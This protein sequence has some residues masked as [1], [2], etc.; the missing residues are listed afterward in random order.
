LQQTVDDLHA[1]L[2]KVGEPG[3]YVLVGHSIGGLYTRKFIADHPD[4]VVGLVLVDAAHPEQLER[5]P[6]FET[7]RETYLR[8]SARFP[9]LARI[10][11]FRLYFAAGGEIDFAGLP[12]RQHDEVTAFWS[13]PEYFTSQR[14]ETI[15][16]P[17]IYADGQSL[18]DLGDLPLAVV[19]QG[20]ADQNWTALQEELA[21]LSSNSTHITVVGSTHGSL[22][23]D[24]QHAQETS[25]AILRIVEAARNNP[26]P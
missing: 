21:S 3:P 1:L 15:A 2:Q 12:E 18:G 23:M 26:P 8:L 4:E 5:F 17:E 14:D 6:Q 24:R 11:L 7:E 9:A 25:A 13:S 19:T 22:A 16:A 10:G 20:N